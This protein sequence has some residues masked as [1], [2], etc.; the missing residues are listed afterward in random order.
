MDF[1]YRITQ[2]DVDAAFRGV[3]LHQSVSLILGDQKL[4]SAQADVMRLMAGGGQYALR[5]D[6]APVGHIGFRSVATKGLGNA[7]W[8]IL[9]PAT[10]ACRRLVN[11]KRR[12]QW[13][14][15]W[16]GDGLPDHLGSNLWSLC[17][18]HIPTMKAATSALQVLKNNPHLSD[19]AL[20]DTGL[21]PRHPIDGDG[22]RAVRTV[23]TA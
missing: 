18:G 14:K 11:Q 15:I 1:Y 6:P 22:I 21:R 19:R 4:T 2:V 8:H 23:L 12:R 16:S 13:I 20:R 5:F 10:Q 7:G 17:R 3:N 9:V